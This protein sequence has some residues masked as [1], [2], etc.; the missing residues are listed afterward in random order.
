[1]NREDITFG[2][3]VFNSMKYG[4][5][6]G[7]YLVDPQDANDFDIVVTR[8]QWDSIEERLRREF[9]FFKMTHETTEY[10]E[11]VHCTS[12]LDENPVPERYVA[13]YRFLDGP[14]NIIVID[15]VYWPAYVAAQQE[16]SHNPMKYKNKEARIEVHAQYC[17]VIK[18]LIA[19]AGHKNAPLLRL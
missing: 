14:V 12:Q 17:N 9:R 16:I 19:Q 4:L 13:D 8:G 1:M 10:K 7:S 11:P 2:C 15:D 3:K 18:N 6:S 5:I